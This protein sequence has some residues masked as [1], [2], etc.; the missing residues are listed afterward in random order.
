LARKLDNASLKLPKQINPSVSE[1]LNQAILKGMA[2]EAKDRPQ[3]MQAW[4]AMLEAPKATPPPSVEPA[5]RKEVIRSKP[6]LNSEGISSKSV[7]IIP[8]GR[9]IG[10]LFNYLLIGYFLAASNTPYIFWIAT[11][12]AVTVAAA[13]AEA[14]GVAWTA[15]MVMAWAVAWAVA[16]SA[17]GSTNAKVNADPIAVVFSL[18]LAGFAAAFVGYTVFIAGEILE[19][20]VG[21]K[22]QGF[23]KVNTFLI[24]ASTSGLGLGLGWLGHRIF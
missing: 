7:R 22:L 19:N 14:W 12:I 8:W 24:L 5:H 21:D 2:L 20:V 10:V 18:L 6:K 11:A 3:S 13:G 16:K 23:N 1:R 9:L 17:L 15:I 4:L